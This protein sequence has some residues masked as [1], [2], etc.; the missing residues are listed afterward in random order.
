MSS[1]GKIIAVCAKDAMNDALG[2]P[3]TGAVYLYSFDNPYGDGSSSTLTP[4]QVIYGEYSSAEFGNA[5]ALSKDGSRMVVGSRS[6]NTQT[7][8]LRIYER[9]AATSK[10]L[11]MAGG[12]IAGQNPS[13]RMGWAVSISPDG[14]GETIAI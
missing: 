9:D 4:L 3:N 8:A 10:W 13:E 5:I 7:G 1:D 11:L 14:N 2:L 6:E 12:M